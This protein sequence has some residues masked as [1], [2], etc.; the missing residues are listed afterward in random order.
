MIEVNPRASRTVPY[1]SKVTGVPMVDLASK[2]M[3]GSALKEL[4]FGTGLYKTPPYFAV[5]VPVFSFEKLSDVN[6]Y[7]GPE[8]KSTGEVLG[9]GKTLSEA[10]FKGFTSA[11]MTIKS[12]SHGQIGA[13]ISVDTHDLNE[14][15]TLAKK[16]GDLGHTIYATPDTAEVISKLG[17]D[18]NTV[19]GIKESENAFKLLESGKID[20]IVY[21]GA[22]MDETLDDYIALHRR[23]VQLG[24][25]CLTS[26]DT[27][28]ALIDTIMSRFNEDNTEL[29]DINS[30]RTQHGKLKFPRCK[31]RAMTISLSRILTE[32]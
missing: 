25:P 15:V 5:K 26:L 19:A 7:L 24:I 17:I 6:S 16:I 9:I 22:L 10:V 27:A 20:Y 11:G 28:N 23:A 32:R 30:M 4:G 2:V 29:V 14:I 8:M 21:T 12:A 3:T 31:P 18:V 13:L 1:I